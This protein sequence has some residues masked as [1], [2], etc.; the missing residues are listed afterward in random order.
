MIEEAEVKQLMIGHR[1]LDD[2]RLKQKCSDKRHRG[3]RAYRGWDAGSSNGST[4][5]ER[6][7]YLVH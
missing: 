1:N 7:S 4:C 5:E 2:V 6:S 3:S